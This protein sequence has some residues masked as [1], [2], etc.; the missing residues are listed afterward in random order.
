M[1][2]IFRFVTFMVLILSLTLAS[3]SVLARDSFRVNARLDTEEENVGLELD[4][5]L[6]YR[7]SFSLGLSLALSDIGSVGIAHLGLRY[8]LYGDSSRFYLKFRGLTRFYDDSVRFRVGVGVGY[9]TY[10]SGNRGALELEL[11]IGSVSGVL[12]IKPSI[13]VSVGINQ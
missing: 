8:Y 5:D 3:T 12:E 13:G 10:I 11:L 6:N 1:L 7:L 2:R 4:Y 9:M